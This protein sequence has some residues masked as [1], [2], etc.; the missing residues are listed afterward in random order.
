VAPYTGPPPVYSPPSAD[1][2]VQALKAQAAHLE[3]A[4]N[5]IRNRIGELEASKKEEGA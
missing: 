3:D 1:A 4:L 5:E 2:E